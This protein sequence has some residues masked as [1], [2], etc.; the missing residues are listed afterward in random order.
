MIR[1]FCFAANSLNRNPTSVLPVKVIAVTRGSRQSASPIVR[2]GPFTTENT[3]CGKPASCHSFAKCSA[4]SGVVWLGFTMT[5]FPAARA[6]ADFEIVNTIGTFQGT[7]AA[8]TP[9]G[10]RSMYEWCS[11]LT[12]ITS[13]RI[14]RAA[15][16]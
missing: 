4:V 5:V 16:L 10:D 7:M 14:L 8:T 11:R 9:T 2:P 3:P 15:A 12:V 1:L 6:G 13:P